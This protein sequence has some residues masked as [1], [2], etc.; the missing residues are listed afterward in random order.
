MPLVP[1]A[2][3]ASAAPPNPLPPP[4]SPPPP[5]T[6]LSLS[7]SAH[8]PPA[9]EAPCIHGSA[10]KSSSSASSSPP[11]APLPPPD[12]DSA[13]ACALRGGRATLVAWVLPLA[14][15]ASRSPVVPPANSPLS[16]SCCRSPLVASP[17]DA[18][19]PANCIS[20]SAASGPSNWREGRLSGGGAPVGPAPHPREPIWSCTIWSCTAI[21]ARRTLE[22]TRTCMSHAVIWAKTIRDPCRWAPTHECCRR[23]NQ[24]NACCS[25]GW[26]VRASAPVEVARGCVRALCEVPGGRNGA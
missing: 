1:A 20:S 19:T 12:S 13:R 2:F 8:R 5:P 10:G 24:R 14:A 17:L 21:G 26:Q 18:R 4:L 11:P 3:P 7:S 15:V 25:A 16:N 23:H 9:R 6:P 22:H